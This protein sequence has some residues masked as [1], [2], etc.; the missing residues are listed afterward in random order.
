MSIK[1]YR[2]LNKT[3]GVDWLRIDEPETFKIFFHRNGID[4]PDSIMDIINAMKACILTTAPWQ[5]P[6][7]FENCIDAFNEMPVF[8]ETLTK[9]PIEN[10]M[11]AVKIM[12]DLAKEANL[13]RVFSND[14]KKYIAAVAISDNFICLPEPLHIANMYIPV[15]DINLRSFC[16]QLCENPEL[17]ADSDSFDESAELIQAAKISAILMYVDQ[18]SQ[19]N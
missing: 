17:L 18:K 10:V 5:N 3:M 13:E 16:E 12:N 9:P 11:Y 1:L 19:E 15:V 2:S 4:I 14:V 6:Y 8:P 7:V